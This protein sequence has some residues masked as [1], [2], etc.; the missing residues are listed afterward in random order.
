MLFLFFISQYQ[1]H[2]SSHNF[3][4]NWARVG[5]KVTFRWIGPFER[6][7]QRYILDLFFTIYR[8]FSVP[9]PDGSGF[10]ADPDPFVFSFNLLWKYRVPSKIFYLSLLFF[11]LV[12]SL[13]KTNLRDMNDV[14]WFNTKGPGSETLR[15]LPVPNVFFVFLEASWGRRS[16]STSRTSS[17]SVGIFC[18]VFT[19]C[20]YTWPV[21]SG[22][23]SEGFGLFCRFWIRTLRCSR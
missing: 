4:K 11:G 7:N 6:L 22:S 16:G 12:L 5:T 1:G 17:W 9:D 23:W 3:Y 8:K 14:L 2:L 21:F 15:K 20:F 18:C 19:L 10:F 13:F